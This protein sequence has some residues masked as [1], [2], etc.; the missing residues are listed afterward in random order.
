MYKYILRYPG[1]SKLY[2]KGYTNRGSRI[3]TPD[4]SD[5]MIF[6]SIGKAEEGKKGF[7]MMI[8]PAPF[9]WYIKK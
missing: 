5:A 8:Q 6:D 4:E 2:L 3:S 1:P 9:K 7:I